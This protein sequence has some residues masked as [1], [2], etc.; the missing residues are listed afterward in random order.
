M[1]T[2]QPRALSAIRLSVATDE[3]TSPGRQREANEFAA[4]SLGAVI[5]GEAEDLDVSASKTTPF[6]RPQ[7]GPWFERPDDFDIVIWWRLDRAVRSMADMSAL[8]GWARK[9]GKRLVFAE[10]PGGA[11]L[12]LD[13]GNVV[14]ELIATLLAFAAQMEAQSIAERVT[15]AQAAMR[16]MPLRWRG[17]RPHYGYKPAELEGGG[18]TLV[19]D[20]EADEVAGPS[21]VSVIERI[22]RELMDGKTASVVAQDLNADGVPS[23]RDYWALTKGRKTGGKTGGAKGEGVQRERFKWTSAVIAR[24]LKSPALLGWK[25]HEGKPVRDAEGRPV[26]ATNT[27]ILTREEFDAIGALLAARSIDNRERK[28]T[29][30]LL[31]RVVHCAHCGGRMYLNK[32]ESKKN[33]APT[34]KCNAHARG[35]KCEAPANVRGDWLD[36]YAEREFLRLV[37]GMRVTETRVIPGYDPTPEIEATTAEYEDH[38]RQEGRQRS[39][40]ARDAWQRRADALDARLAELEGREKIEARTEVVHLARSYADEWRDADTAGRRAML[41]EAGAYLTVKRGTRGG[42]RKLDERRVSFALREEFFAEA[43][44]ELRGLVVAA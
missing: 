12:E 2:N 13:M 18:W 42:W 9:H 30:S 36:E 37:G 20:N 32:Q 17:S 40:A 41:I 28:D 29:H 23:P 3:T 22:I 39:N 16:A 19:P 4:A 43:S 7:L 1:K 34:Y 26:M 35:E 31:L 44:D 38:M 25:L 27:P 21:P 10:G 14:G 15:G 11:R 24:L 6:E 8:V 5:V 33:Q